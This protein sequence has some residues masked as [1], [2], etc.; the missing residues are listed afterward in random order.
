MSLKGLEDEL[1]AST[2]KEL[3]E[4]FRRVEEE[5]SKIGEQAKCE[6]EEARQRVARELEEEKKVLGSQTALAEVRARMLVSE[7][8]AKLLE[9]ALDEAWVEFKNFRNSNKAY[10]EFMEKLLAESK[11]ELGSS[12]VFKCAKRD[13]QLVSKFGKVV[14]SIETAG[15]FIALDSTGKIRM[16][17]TLESI[18][19]N[20]KGK[21]R[22][23]AAVL[24]LNSIEFKSKKKE[25][26]AVA[27]VE[28]VVEAPVAQVPVPVV[29][30]APVFKLSRKSPKKGKGNKAGKA[31]KVGRG[32][33]KK[34]GKN[35]SKKKR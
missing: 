19:E 26:K 3:E 6:V 9:R 17:C 10:S 25:K 14:E 20:G 22:E 2:R 5:E 1:A 27:E 31:S 35:N 11:Q 15:G 12:C 7:A 33:K 30:S 34:S 4:I 8:K 24:L 28:E 29:P 13:S 16:D 32:A 21:A 23:A 18:W